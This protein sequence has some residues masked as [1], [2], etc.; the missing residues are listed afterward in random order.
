MCIRDSCYPVFIAGSLLGGAK[1]WYYPLTKE[2]GFLPYVK[3]IPEDVA[4]N[5]LL[6]TSTTRRPLC[7]H[8]GRWSP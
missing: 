5:C 2:H 8:P 4:R 3:D 1:P 6:Y 7:G